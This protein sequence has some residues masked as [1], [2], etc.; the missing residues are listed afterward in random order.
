MSQDPPGEKPG[1]PRGIR[2]V[3]VG[4]VL[5]CPLLMCA[6]GALKIL[7][8][9]QGGH[10]PELIVVYNGG[11]ILGTTLAVLAFSYGQAIPDRPR[12]RKRVVL[13]GEFFSLG[14]LLFL[15]AAVTWYSAIAADQRNPF[16]EPWPKE[17]P[18][19]ASWLS[20]LSRLICFVGAV[21]SHIGLYILVDVLLGRC[22]LRQDGDVRELE[23]APT[24]EQARN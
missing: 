16:V 3:L 21:V 22:V 15:V 13:A 17:P 10:R 1:I 14:S 4:L 12:T 8:P 11:F 9:L 24:A 19:D 20:P 6:A 7:D 5:Y 2:C 23:A 18:P